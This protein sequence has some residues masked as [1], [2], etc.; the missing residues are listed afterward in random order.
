M[1][2]RVSEDY[3]LPTRSRVGSLIAAKWCGEPVSQVASLNQ[4]NIGHLTGT[5]AAT[6]LS[7]R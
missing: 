4:V 5:Y 7:N 1:P 3:G 6:Q 2:P